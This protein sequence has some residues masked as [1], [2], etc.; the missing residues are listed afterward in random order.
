M[1]RARCRTGGE[2]H[3]TRHH[4]RSNRP[5]HRRRRLGQ[6]PRRGAGPGGRA[7]AAG[8]GRRA[9]PARAATGPPGPA[10]ARS[11]AGH[12]GGHRAWAGLAGAPHQAAQAGGGEHLQ[13]HRGAEPAPRDAAHARARRRRRA[14]ALRALLRPA[15]DAGGAAG[16]QPRLRLHHQ[17]GGVRPH[18]QPRGEGR[19]RHQGE[20]LGRAGVRGE[21]AGARPRHGRGAHQA[22]EG[23]REAAHG[24]PGRLRRAGAGG[25]RPRHRQP[26][27]L[28]RVG[29]LRHRLGQGPAAHGEP[30]RRLP[31][32]RRGHQP[33]QLG[34]AALQHEGRGGGHQ[35][36]HHLAADR[37]RA[38][39]SPSPS[40]WPSSSCHSSPPARCRG[41]SWA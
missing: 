30:V 33:G 38:S 36:R 21:D 4:P 32:D 10:V 22:A 2:Q 17:R 35:H 12:V 11:G 6:G 5:R 18:Q 41:A 8:P 31:A 34:R 15:R 14:A 23:G 24:G 39:A 1:S 3:A 20:A 7:G 16:H 19:H 25:V 28:P 26:A 27:R 9:C 29:H 37:L 40:T 13:H